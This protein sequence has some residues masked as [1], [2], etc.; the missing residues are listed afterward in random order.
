VRARIL[1]EIALLQLVVTA[2]TLTLTVVVATYDDALRAA[3]I[4]VG[5]PC[6]LL[7]CWAAPTLHRR[8]RR[9]RLLERCAR[10]DEDAIATLEALDLLA[11]RM[12]PPTTM[13]AFER[14]ERSLACDR[15]RDATRELATIR[16]PSRSPSFD[17]RVLDARARAEL[18]EGDGDAAIESARDA[19]AYSDVADAPILARATRGTLGAAQ[20]ST[21]R[22]DEAIALLS[23]IEACPVPRE[24]RASVRYHLGE[25]LAAIGRFDDARAAYE[26]ARDVERSRWSTRARERLDELERRGAFR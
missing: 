25:A 7:A 23:T 22:F 19:V 9:T 10:G 20:V 11:D 15:A 6:W 2:A 17:A 18:R 21:A 4:F 13:L 1:A 3:A 5:L 8:A 24:V 26:R 16:I 12:A 14:A